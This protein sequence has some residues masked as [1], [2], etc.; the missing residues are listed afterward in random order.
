VSC[1]G[2]NKLTAA[3]ATVG[4]RGDQQVRGSTKAPDKLSPGF[5]RR[6]RNAN[7]LVMLHRGKRQSGAK[8]WRIPPA[9]PVRRKSTYE[10][11]EKGFLNAGISQRSYC[12]DASSR[13]RRFSSSFTR[14][15]GARRGLHNKLYFSAL[16]RA[17]GGTPSLNISPS[18]HIEVHTNHK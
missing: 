13:P 4:E 10:Q 5:I 9:F 17:N 7:P 3:T 11:R 14:A 15:E 8:G 6:P 12:H 16:L 1:L 18:P 2:S